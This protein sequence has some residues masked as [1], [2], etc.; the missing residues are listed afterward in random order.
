[1][2]VSEPLGI[3]VRLQQGQRFALQLEGPVR[4]VAPVAAH[5]VL[6]A[7]GE[8]QGIAQGAREGRGFLAQG[9]I[10]ERNSVLR[11]PREAVQRLHDEG[12][13]GQC[14]REVQSLASQALLVVPL[15]I[16]VVRLREQQQQLH[17]FRAALDT[18]V[19][20]RRSASAEARRRHASLR[21]QPR[22]DR[23]PSQHGGR[24][25]F[26]QRVV[27]PAMQLP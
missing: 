10:T 19:R 1:M 17:P 15:S 27:R 16:A 20:P 9:S 5:E 7:T 2:A 24:R 12:R 18:P 22:L 8:Q 26:F 11:T 23:V 13:C 4:I 3:S 14:A 6:K 25:R 21:V